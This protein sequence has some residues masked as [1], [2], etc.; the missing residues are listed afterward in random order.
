ML[1]KTGIP[2]AADVDEVF[3]S[4]ARLAEGSVAVIE[5]YQRIPC[6]PCATSCPRGA[7]QPFG[8]INDRPTINEADCNGCSLCLTKCPGIAIMIVD[9]TWSEDRALIKLPYEFRPLP[10]K[11]DEVLALDRAGNVVTKVEVIQVLLNHAMNKVP[12]ISIAVDKSLVKVVRNIR[13]D[14]RGSAIVC[15]CNDLTADD[16]RDLI[17]QGAT[18]IDELKRV[19]RLGMGP[20]QGRNCIPLVAG[21]L[22]RALGVPVAQ[23]SP[24]TFRPSVK[25]IALGDLAAYNE[26]GDIKS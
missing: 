23:L 22:S 25:S 6:N 10:E 18:S 8:D 14:K 1:E 12:I 11:G 16:I 21:E 20:C 26:Q 7:I 13:L 2:T 4:E 19:A 9:M 3:P 17:A 24:G 15:R 5:Y